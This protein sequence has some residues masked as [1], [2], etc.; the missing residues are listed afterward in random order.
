MMIQG[1]DFWFLNELIDIILEGIR[2][3][4]TGPSPVC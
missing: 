2:T 3:K 1:D 4:K